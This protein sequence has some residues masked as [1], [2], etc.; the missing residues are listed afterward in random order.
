MIK[1][2]IAIGI[3]NRTFSHIFFLFLLVLAC[4]SYTK[5]PKEMFPPSS[6]DV[7]TIQGHYSGANSTILDK[8]IVQEIEKALQNNQYISKIN[9]LISNGTFHIN[10]EI[11]E[12]KYIQE[13]IDDIKNQIQN[14]QQDLPRDMDMPTVK[15]LENY[16]PLLDISISS[17]I[18]E[19]YIE[20]AKELQDDIKKLAN[21]H[22]V[23]MDKS[24]D[25]LMI[26]SLNEQKLSAYGISNEKIYNA[27]NSLYS[28]HP[29]GSITT[30]TQKYYLESKNSG[31]GLDEILDLEILIDDKLI[32][33]RSVA[34]V[35]YDYENQEVITRTNAQQSVLINVK[36]AKQGDSIKLSQDIRK[37]LSNYKDRYS[38]IDFEVISDSSFWIKNRLN[39]IASN[40]IIGLILLF[41]SIWFFI[42]LKI[43][44]VV[45]LGIPVSFAFGLIGLDFFDASL[46]TLSMIGV[47]LSLGILVDEAIVVS[48]NIHRHVDM[49]KDLNQACI[50]ATYEML[51]ILF[52]SMLTT[53]IA[54]LPLTMLS[55]GLGVFIKIIPLMVII[56]VVSSFVESFLFLPLHY[57]DFSFGFL[58]EKKHS[59][60]DK[61]WER[62]SGVYKS[63]LY[64]FIKKRYL[65]ALFFIIFSFLATFML[66]KSSSF[67]LFA[68]F[69]AM[70]INIT[71]KVKNSSLL[72]TLNDAQKLESVL[73]DSLDKKNVASI[74]T[75]VGMNS[76]GRS[77]HERGDNL[78]TITVNLKEKTYD[79]FF[80][81]VINPIFTPYKDKNSSQRTREL[82]AKEIKEKIES[83]IKKDN[84]GE[85][86]LEFDVD[87]PQTGVVKSDVEIAFSHKDNK[88]LEES[89]KKVQEKMQ[90]IEGVS[91]IK[92]DMR[93]DD[94]RAQIRLNSYGE[95]LGFTQE[96]VVSK[97]RAFASLKKLSKIVDT[98][99][100][101][102]ELGVNFLNQ[103]NLKSLYNLSLNSPRDECIVSLHD[104]ANITFIKDTATIKKE[105]FKKIFTLW[106]NF[107]KKKMSSRKFYKLLEPTMQELKN[108]GVSVLVKGEEKT[109]N[110]IKKD[111]TISLI[112]TLFGILLVLVWL[113]SSLWL[114][115]FALSVLPFSLL[116]V[117][118]GHKIMGINISFSS[119]LGFVGLIGIIIN[120]TL[121]MLNI[122]KESKN[123]DELIQNASIRV[124]PIL[125]TSITTVIGLATLIFFASGESLL[126]QPLAVSMGF[127]LIYATII[128]LYYLPIFFSIK[129]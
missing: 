4:I 74:S 113:F 101:L 13:S 46:N 128:N 86:F 88:I 92:N 45:I 27:I 18:D 93:L 117:L 98:K 116:G 29:I 68:E 118:L 99:S 76:D 103:N 31:V 38:E 51:P 80:N 114:S 85:N 12:S 112:F 56:L 50:D 110:Q 104:V 67:Q 16:F 109:N 30:Q 105:N 10:C 65:W 90:G 57:K 69:D 96:S 28:L 79:D 5:I 24:Y 20:V 108:S 22:S 71:A 47:L 100:N 35:N 126:M 63:S 55:G 36:K 34:D 77:M 89:I 53:I 124:R 84:L 32:P 58:R 125:L 6:L 43:A 19:N 87:I 70:S 94:I 23:S 75:I 120:D 9:T 48:E 97:V 129:R 115:L 37:I 83:L 1:E 73:L 39:T 49:N 95:S 78:F 111:I 7:V 2:L 26:I 72:L 44:I 106:A 61:L 33:L 127:G 52:A 41:L 107:D 121:I 54:F 40:I 66:L 14:L 122:I 21:L 3:K 17:N 82:S 11:K 59:Y 42:S 102:V 81:E 119:V 91:Q 15:A 25:L 62:V 8:L 123:L 60:R 64:F